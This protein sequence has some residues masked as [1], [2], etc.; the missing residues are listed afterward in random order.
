MKKLFIILALVCLCFNM[1]ANAKKRKIQKANAQTEAFRYDI[2]I[3]SVGIQ[4]TYLVKAWSYSK[5][6]TVAAEQ[7][8]KNAVH[9]VLYKGL[10]GKTGVSGKA[11]LLNSPAEIEAFKQYS[12]A[13][14][15][16]SGEYRKFAELATD[17]RV[18]AEDFMKVGREYKVGL[19]V[20]VKV[21]ALRKDLETRG[22]IK[23][24]SSG[25]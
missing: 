17:G 12:D 11:P 22:I 25:F 20:S 13:F 16:A 2:E 19:V 23:G 9:G 7:A 4:G 8:M 5:R 24:L 14:F 10:A 21:D 1:D 6:S 3:E 15:G 18:A